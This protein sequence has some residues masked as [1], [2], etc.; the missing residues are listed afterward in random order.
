MVKNQLAN[1][2]DVGSIPGL[3]RL[4]EGDRGNP[5]QYPFLGNS[6]DRGVWRASPWGFKES[7]TTEQLSTY[8][9]KS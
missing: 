1:A 7:D 5:F 8:A 2:G 9:C 4:P 6:M 3:G